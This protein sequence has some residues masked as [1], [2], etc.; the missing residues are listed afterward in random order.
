MSWI[1][2]GICNKQHVKNASY[3][4]NTDDIGHGSYLMTNDGYSWHHTDS[5]INSQIQNVLFQTNDVV[6]MTF[7]PKKKTIKF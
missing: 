2:L 6:I 5:S 3:Y 4:F 7:D 1:G